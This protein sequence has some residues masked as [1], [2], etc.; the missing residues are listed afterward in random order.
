LAD[1]LHSTDLHS[2]G[3]ATSFTATKKQSNEAGKIAGNGRQMPRNRYDN[4][5]DRNWHIR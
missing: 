1:A 4:I 2:Q 3:G 5:D